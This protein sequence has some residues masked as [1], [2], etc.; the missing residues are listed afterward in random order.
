MILYHLNSTKH[1]HTRLGIEFPFS[2]KFWKEYAQQRKVDARGKFSMFRIRKIRSKRMPTRRRRNIFDDPGDVNS[3]LPIR[4]QS[5][6][7]RA[8]GE[9]ENKER[10]D[11]TKGRI[12]ENSTRPTR[13]AEGR[14]LPREEAKC[15]RELPGRLAISAIFIFSVLL[16]AACREVRQASATE[17]VGRKFSI[18]RR[19]CFE[20]RRCASTAATGHRRCL[21]RSRQPPRK[22]WPMMVS[23]VPRRWSLSP[24]LSLSFSLFLHEYKIAPPTAGSYASLRYIIIGRFS[25]PWSTSGSR[26]AEGPRSSLQGNRCC[27][28]FWYEHAWLSNC[29]RFD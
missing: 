21:R 4:N 9:E 25:F 14:F 27:F 11:K 12:I 3:R 15:A 10:E 1:L 6:R 19:R 20:V 13:R 18:D 17:R 28:Y 5:A 22:P 2:W 7:A 24:S 26:N 23:C 29:S 16:R 8:W